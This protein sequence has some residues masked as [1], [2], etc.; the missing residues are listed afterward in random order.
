MNENLSF[1]QAIKRLEEIVYKLETGIED[2][3]K[4][5]ALYEEG[6]KLVDY[7]SEKLHAVENKIETLSK[8]TA[9]ESDEE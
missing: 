9:K 8:E 5:V 7:C 4:T 1:E 2:L 6:S 3:E